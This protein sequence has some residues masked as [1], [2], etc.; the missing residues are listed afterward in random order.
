MFNTDVDIFYMGLEMYHTGVEMFHLGVL[1]AKLVLKNLFRALVI[2]IIN[3]N[4]WYLQE[5]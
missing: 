1:I 3:S 5:Y 4:L 2:V